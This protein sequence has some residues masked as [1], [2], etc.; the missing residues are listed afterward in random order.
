[1]AKEVSGSA[2]IRQSF[3]LLGAATGLVIW[4]H[5]REWRLVLE[6]STRALL[7]LF[8]SYLCV[9][10]AWWLNQPLLALPA[11]VLGLAGCLHVVAGGDASRFIRP[12]FTGFIACLGVILLFPVLDWPLRQMAGLNAAR[13]LQGI[14]FTPELAVILQPAPKLLLNTGR[15]LFEVATECNGFGL[16]T[17]GAVLAVL[18]AGIAGRRAGALLWLVPLALALGFGFNLLRILIIC[19]LAPYFPLHYNALHETAGVIMLWSGLGLVGWLA[20]R[21][22]L[23]ARTDPA[24]PVN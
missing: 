8:A 12:L 10:A 11:F 15:N 17:S 21:P 9:V 22:P 6:V 19:V 1:M 4:Q 3:L 24:K 20:W 23:N 2:Q 16:I 5:L 14:G 18:A 13:L 7:L